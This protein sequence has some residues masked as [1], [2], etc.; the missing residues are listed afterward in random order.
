MISVS[1]GNGALRRLPRTAPGKV[2]CRNWRPHLRLV[3]QSSSA[4]EQLRVCQGATVTTYPQVVSGS[5]GIGTPTGCELFDLEVD[6]DTL[7][8]RHH[9]VDT[10]GACDKWRKETLNA[11]SI[12]ISESDRKNRAFDSSID[13]AGSERLSIEGEHCSSRWITAI[14]VVGE[15]EGI[16]AAQQDTLR[17]LSC[18]RKGDRVATPG[19]IL[20]TF[21]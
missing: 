2:V 11:S 9:H 12:E 8:D 21:D 10:I 4:R 7:A 1:P 17:S 14:R 3:A 19:G 5:D 20:E 16:K 6:A 15:T 13:I 18:P